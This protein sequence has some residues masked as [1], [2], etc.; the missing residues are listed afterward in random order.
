[1]KEEEEGEKIELFFS[2]VYEFLTD[3]ESFLNPVPCPV[4]SPVGTP[5]A[6]TNFLDSLHSV[7][8]ISHSDS[9]VSVAPS[10]CITTS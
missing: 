5:V 4:I 1:M 3:F 2:N 7:P 10:Q 9:P 6:I 8:V